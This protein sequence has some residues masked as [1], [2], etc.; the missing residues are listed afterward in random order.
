MVKPKRT[1]YIR[2]HTCEI[3]SG[4]TRYA[5]RILSQRFFLVTTGT[6]TKTGV[7][8]RVNCIL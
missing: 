3:V 2:T 4:A 1:P 7:H 8:F 5:P 6:E